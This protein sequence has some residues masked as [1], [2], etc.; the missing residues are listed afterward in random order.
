MRGGAMQAMQPEVPSM[1]LTWFSVDDADA[2][3]GRI[4]NNGGTLL[5]PLMDMPGVGRMGLGRMGVVADPTGAAFGV[6][7][8]AA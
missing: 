6:I 2:A 1:W 7:K 8:P 5:A 3:V 4:T